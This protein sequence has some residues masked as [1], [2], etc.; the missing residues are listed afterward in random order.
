M[1]QSADRVHA[2]WPTTRVHLQT[3]PLGESTLGD[4]RVV[5]TKSG[6]HGC[7]LLQLQTVNDIVGAPADAISDIVSVCVR[8]CLF[9]SS[10]CNSRLQQPVAAVT[11]RALTC[12]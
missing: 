7:E 9:Q 11:L 4:L 8:S 3:D 5:D 10:A 2:L 6:G 12:F 1:G